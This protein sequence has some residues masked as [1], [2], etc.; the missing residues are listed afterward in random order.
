MTAALLAGAEASDV[1][2]DE[3]PSAD[4]VPPPLASVAGAELAALVVAL[5]EPV[6][7]AELL[8][9]VPELGSAGV[10]AAGTGE[11]EPLDVPEPVGSDAGAVVV[12]LGGLVGDGVPDD[13]GGPLGSGAVEDAG[14]LPAVAAGGVNPPVAAELGLPVVDVE[15]EVAPPDV[16]VVLEGDDDVVPTEVEDTVPGGVTMPSGPPTGPV[17]RAAGR[18]GTEPSSLSRV[19]GG[20]AGR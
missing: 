4:A 11:A 10:V 2:D 6:A 20:A 7:G 12:P 5:V 16:V 3:L 14:P 15:F 18:A 17:G 1:P 9:S 19:V 8:P 13:G